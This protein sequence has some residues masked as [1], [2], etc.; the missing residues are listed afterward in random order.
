L[1]KNT[2]LSSLRK[3]S[4]AKKFMIED[5]LDH[6]T[7]GK[8]ANG[9]VKLVERKNAPETIKNKLYALKIFE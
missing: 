9:V 7:L 8:G 6:G 4:S 1:K 2:N 5:F 3:T